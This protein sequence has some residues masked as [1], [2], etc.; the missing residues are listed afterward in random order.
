MEVVTPVFCSSFAF[1]CTQTKGLGFHL[2]VSFSID[3]GGVDGDMAEPGSDSVD[4]NASAKK[5]RGCS[6][7]DGMRPDAFFV[8]LRH[9]VHGDARIARHD[10]MDSETCQRLGAPIQEDLLF[11]I[12]PGD[13]VLQRHGCGGPQRA[14]A[15]LAALAMKTHRRQGTVCAAVQAEIFDA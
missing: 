10:F 11:L 5:M 9:A 8:H 14:D 2:K 7:P 15:N 6:V 4:V 3:V 13:K 1:Y 12:P